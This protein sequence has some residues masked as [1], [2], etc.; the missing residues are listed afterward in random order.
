MKTTNNMKLV[1]CLLL[2]FV[3]VALCAPTPPVWPKAFSASVVVANVS[4]NFPPRFV[5][6]FNDVG[7]NAA[8]IDGLRYFGPNVPPVWVQQYINGAQKLEYIVV[9][10][11]NDVNC[12][13]VPLRG[14]IISPDFSSFRYEGQVLVGPSGRVLNRWGMYNGTSNTFQQYLE[15]PWS[16]EP[17]RLSLFYQIGSQVEEEVWE[18]F[19]FDAA[20]QDASLFVIPGPIKQI[21]G[22]P[23]S[24]FEHF[25]TISMKKN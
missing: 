10:G 15:D 17:A 24:P 16:R 22:G 6:W 14:P 5:R 13:T 21:C 18:F 25:G 9:F 20:P 3:A 12:F 1:V 7:Q 23:S 8:R 19:E 11:Q 2:A 4:G